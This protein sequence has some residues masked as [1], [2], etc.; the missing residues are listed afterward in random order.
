MTTLSRT[1][2]EKKKKRMQLENRLSALH[3][4]EIYP[5]H[6]TRK[7]FQLPEEQN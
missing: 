4:G 6:E 1:T 7:A 2:T 3:A 5:L